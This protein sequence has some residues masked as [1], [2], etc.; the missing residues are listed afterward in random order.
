MK[1]PAYILKF[2]CSSYSDRFFEVMGDVEGARNLFTICKSVPCC[3]VS[4]LF[5]QPFHLKRIIGKEKEP[6]SLKAVEKTTVFARN[7]TEIVHF[8]I[9]IEKMKETS[10]SSSLYDNSSVR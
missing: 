6:N 3:Q 10:K 1:L 9:G 2:S 8:K 5:S 4:E 7:R